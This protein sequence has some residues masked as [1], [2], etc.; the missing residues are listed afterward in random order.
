MAN[1]KFNIDYVQKGLGPHIDPLVYCLDT[2]EDVFYSEIELKKNEIIVSDTGSNP[3]FAIQVRWNIEGFGFIYTTADNEGEYYS[4]NNKTYN[5]V[6]ELAKTAVYRNRKRIEEFNSFEWTPDKEIEHLNSLSK[7]LLNDAGKITNSF[8]QSIAA[9]KALMYA[10]WVADY[11]ELSKSK[12]DINNNPKRN[13]FLYG[14]DGRGYYQMENKD[15]FM[16][17]F[18]ELFNYA[19]I[20]HYLKGDVFN[21]EDVEGEKKFEERSKLLHE[22]RKND[23]IVAGR[24]LF[25]THFWVTPDWLRAKSFDKL[26][27]YL[28]DHIKKTVGYYKD[29]IAVWEVVNELHDWAN[30]LEL[31]PEQAVELTKFACDVARSVNPNVKLLINNCRP[32]GEYVQLK[33]YHEKPACYRQRTP[34]QFIKDLVDAGVD[35]DTIGIQVYYAFHPASSAIKNIERFKEFNKKVQL[36]EVG[37]P[38][39][40][41]KSEFCDPDIESSEFPYDWH[42]HWDEELQADWLD[43]TFSYA[44]SQPW[45]EGANWYDFVDPHSF[46]KKGGL[47]RSPNGE[48]KSGVYRLMQLKEEWNKK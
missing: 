30:E 14:C 23:I 42:R 12:F 29:E 39:A 25:W 37:A 9:Q 34:H 21:F 22:L 36:S 48:R 13:D 11:I 32:F 43:Y 6:Y 18:K 33:K 40:G 2:N 10:H 16:E 45:I 27:I 24:P 28:E 26:L 31:S 15:L 46:L 20:T 19:T 38:S 1:I 41:I 7:E 35:F 47:L 17:R 5:L 3:K 44:Y 8:E 4:L